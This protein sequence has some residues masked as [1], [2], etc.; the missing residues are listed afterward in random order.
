MKLQSHQL[1]PLEPADLV[2]SL[3]DD[4]RAQ[5]DNVSIVPA[6]AVDGMDSDVIRMAQELHSPVVHF[7]GNFTSAYDW[8]DG[9]GPIDKRVSMLNLSWGI[10]DYNTFGTNEF[11]QFCKFITRC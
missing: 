9:V 2:L 5:V 11:L 6:D 7:G 3:S 4:A 1:A 8:K 10:P